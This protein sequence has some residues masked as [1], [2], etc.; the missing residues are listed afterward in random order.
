MRTGKELILATKPF[1]VDSSARSWWHILSTAFL[2]AVALAG[3]SG[4]SQLARQ[5]QARLQAYRSQQPYYEP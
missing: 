4:Q 5:L 2:L 1:T 3:T